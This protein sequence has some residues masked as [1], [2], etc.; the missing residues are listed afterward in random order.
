MKS[1]RVPWA[2]CSF[3][4]VVWTSAYTTD[5]EHIGTDG[6]VIRD[7]INW[8]RKLALSSTSIYNHENNVSDPIVFSQQ[9]Q[10]V[11]WRT[12]CHPLLKYSWLGPRW[13]QQRYGEPNKK[14]QNFPCPIGLYTPATHSWMNSREDNGALNSPVSSLEL[15]KL[16]ASAHWYEGEWSSP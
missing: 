9:W 13:S 8:W 7:F 3:Y 16:R 10:G 12:D 4:P 11:K 15:L 2:P 5:Q 6:I 14:S 1:Q